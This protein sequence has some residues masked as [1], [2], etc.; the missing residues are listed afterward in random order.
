M[1]TQLDKTATSW[2]VKKKD[3][4]S[5]WKIEHVK[6]FNIYYLGHSTK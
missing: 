3:Q 6:V 4:E 2:F 1:G 5:V